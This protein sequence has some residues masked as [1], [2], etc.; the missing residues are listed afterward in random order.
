MAGVVMSEGDAFLG[1][2]RGAR[3]SDVDELAADM[4]PVLG[5]LDAGPD[6]V[7]GDQAVVSG[8]AVDLQDAAEALQYPFGMLTAASWGIRVQ[9]L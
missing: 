7:R 1:D 8:I 9:S 6:A 4:R 2:R 3:A 5:E